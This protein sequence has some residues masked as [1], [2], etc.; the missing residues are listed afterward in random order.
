MTGSW[1]ISAFDESEFMEG[2]VTD[3]DLPNLSRREPSSVFTFV[4][5]SG[6]EKYRLYL[7]GEQLW[8]ARV[9]QLTTDG[10]AEVVNR[11]WSIYRVAPWEGELNPVFMLW[12]YRT[13]VE[14]F[15]AL[16]GDYRSS[17]EDDTC[18]NVT[19]ALVERSS[20]YRIFK[21]DASCEACLLFDG[22][23]Y[24]L[25]T[26]FG[27]FG[28]T[29]FLTGDLNEDGLMELY[30]TYSWGSGIHRSHA[31][32][33]DPVSRKT[34]DLSVRMNGD[35]IFLLDHQNTICLYSADSEIT[36]EDFCHMTLTAGEMLGR[37]VYEEGRILLANP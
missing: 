11:I 4:D 17:Y 15:L 29:S 36:V 7:M 21:F 25:G 9:M 33:F 31:A 34:V 8:L 26:G 22:A 5:D 27:G 32:Y 35:M 18:W 13:D 37:P 19:P 12:G 28:V 14:E 24:P 10:Q 2:V 1:H 23:V 30:F 6:H 16:L 3:D 20:I